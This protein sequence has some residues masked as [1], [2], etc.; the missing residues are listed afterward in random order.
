MC[1]TS[2]EHII[3]A[4]I[5]INSS[6]EKA[7]Y[8]LFSRAFV[9]MHTSS[10]SFRSQTNKSQSPSGYSFKGGVVPS[11]YVEKGTDSVAKG[12]LHL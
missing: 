3:K 6:S 7:L 5:E 10:V 2:L 8:I 12:P 11:R 9:G 1:V 4:S